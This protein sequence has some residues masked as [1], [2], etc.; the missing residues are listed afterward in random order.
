MVTILGMVAVTIVVLASGSI[1]L[2]MVI[3]GAPPVPSKSSEIADVVDI[4]RSTHL[5]QNPQIFELGCG[6]GGLAVALARAFPTARVTGIELSILPWFVARLRACRLPNLTVLR[7]DFHTSEL[8]QADA[9]TC[10]LMMAPMVALANTLDK[11]LRPGTRVAALTFWFR[12]RK[13]TDVRR[14]PGVRGAGG[15]YR[16][17]GRTSSVTEP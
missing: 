17:P 6:F 14:G 15:L 3:T 7:Q 2:F 16:W 10:Y 9:V 5:P 11:K 13:P 8:E 1:L 4:L 12:G